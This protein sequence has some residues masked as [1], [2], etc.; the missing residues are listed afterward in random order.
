M[1]VER[2]L[3][4]DVF[5]RYRNRFSRFSVDRRD[6]IR[7]VQNSDR[8]NSDRIGPDQLGPV[9]VGSGRINSDRLGST[10]NK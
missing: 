6:K 1:M 4:T 9:R 3:A 5:L 7:Q 2:T 10:K 8:I